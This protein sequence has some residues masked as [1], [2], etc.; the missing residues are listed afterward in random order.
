LSDLDHRE[1]IKGSNGPQPVWQAAKKQLG[2][3]KRVDGDVALSKLL[4]ERG[5]PL[6]KVIDPYRRIGKDHSGFALRRGM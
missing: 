1:L 3:N 4:G 6:A 2:N 5:I